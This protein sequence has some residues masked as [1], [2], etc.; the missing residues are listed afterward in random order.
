MNNRRGE[1]L[2]FTGEG[3]FNQGVC[4]STHTVSDPGLNALAATFE[5]QNTKNSFV[6]FGAHQ[7]SFYFWEVKDSGCGLVNC[8]LFS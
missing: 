8:R 2:H 7:C 5:S 3:S 6:C 1:Q 4:H